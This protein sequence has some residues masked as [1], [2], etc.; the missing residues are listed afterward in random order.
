[1]AQDWTKDELRASVEAYREMQRLDRAGEKGFKTRIYKDLA[2]RFG[3]TSK[4]FEFRMQNISAVLALLGREWL[5]G[6]KPATHVGARVAEQIEALINE[7]EDV[8]ATPRAAFEAAVRERLKKPRS[9]P[10]TGR[11]APKKTTTLVS[12]FVRDPDVKAWVLGRA[13][14]KCESC[15]QPAPFRTPDGMPYLEVHHIKTLADGG[16]DRVS[17][18]AGLCPNCH[19]RMHFGVDGAELRARLYS[20]VPELKPE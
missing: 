18:A 8:H 19:R 11:A 3:R 7:A 17:N 15:A 10:P 16:S 5:A 1:M 6:L 2:R 13:A 4:A 14:A 20:S 12:S 9:K